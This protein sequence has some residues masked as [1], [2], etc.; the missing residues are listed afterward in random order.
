MRDTALI[1]GVA[2]M[3]IG[4]VISRRMTEG[5]FGRLEDATRLRL[6][7]AFASMRVWNIVPLFVLVGGVVLLRQ[8]F[9]QYGMIAWGVFAAALVGYLALLHV[10]TMRKMA[11][12]PLPDEYLK[13]YRRARVVCYLS[14]LALWGAILLPM[15]SQ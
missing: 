13:A 9:V 5:A 12:L 3:M 6:M 1:V 15:I 10:M 14:L 11:T 4:T 2:V 7:D 8:Q